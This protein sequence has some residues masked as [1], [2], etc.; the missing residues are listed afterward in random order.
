MALSLASLQSR[1]LLW[2]VRHPECS[3]REAVLEARYSERPEDIPD[4]DTPEAAAKSTGK[5]KSASRR[6]PK[7]KPYPAK[8]YPVQPPDADK[9][10]GAEP[11]VIL[12]GKVR[13]KVTVKQLLGKTFSGSDI[14]AVLAWAARNQYYV[15]IN[16]TRVTDGE[17]GNYIVEPYSYRIRMTR[18]GPRLMLFAHHGAHRSIHGFIFKRIHSVRLSRKKFR[19]RWPIEL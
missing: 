9:E 7:S 4:L 5:G 17:N 16:Y 18:I 13:P 15:H 14:K 1:P 19:P 11:E 8:K 2:L 12:R 3:V 6:V 10:E